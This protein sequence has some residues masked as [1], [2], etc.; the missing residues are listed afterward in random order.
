MKLTFRDAN[1]GEIVLR[2]FAHK[3]EDGFF[4]VDRLSPIYETFDFIIECALY[5]INEGGCFFD[6]V[7]DESG[8]PYVFW[9]LTN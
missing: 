1:T 9:A 4:Y 6:S 7:E 5:G 3:G 2:M 8:K